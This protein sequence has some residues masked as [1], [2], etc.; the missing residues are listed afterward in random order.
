MVP[1]AN[2]PLRGSLPLKA[3]LESDGVIILDAPK[4][5]LEKAVTSTID[6]T[7]VQFKSG[8]DTLLV[9]SF[10]RAEGEIVFNARLQRSWGEE[11]RV[12]LDNRFKTQTPTILVH[13]QGDGYEVLIDWVHVIWFE[14]R[15]KEKKI[16]LL[17][18]GVN[19]SQNPVLG[20]GLKVKVFPSLK[21][22][23]NH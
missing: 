6:N 8:S 23:F 20:D 13:D 9:I 7:Q 12:S 14:K 1:K 22:L 10:R 11:V 15:A 21:Q 5:D 16:T 2:L 17:T 4:L 18:Y 3:P 19:E